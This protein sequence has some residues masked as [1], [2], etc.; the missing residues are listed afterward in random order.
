[1]KQCPVWTEESSAKDQVLVQWFS[2]AK[3]NPAQ[4]DPLPLEKALGAAA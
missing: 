2:R 4:K 1:M 3:E